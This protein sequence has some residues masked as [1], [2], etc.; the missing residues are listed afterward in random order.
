MCSGRAQ[1]REFK[2]E[3]QHWRI[4]ASVTGCVDSM[5]GCAKLRLASVLLPEQGRL[6]L[7]GLLQ[8][9]ERAP[10]QEQER[11][12]LQ[13]LVPAQVRGL[14]R[15]QE[16]RLLRYQGWLRLRVQMQHWEPALLRFDERVLARGPVMKPERGQ[17]RLLYPAPYRRLLR[18]SEQEPH[19][20]Q[21]L[22][23]WSGG[24]GKPGQC[25]SQ[26]ARLRNSAFW[27]LL[28]EFCSIRAILVT[29]RAGIRV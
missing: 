24:R 12:L 1:P 8:R 6:L 18:M 14:L 9:Q 27:Y 2:D 29:A 3:V 13:N 17:E 4:L 11:V 28:F 19:K 23:Q 21:A 20:G 15:Q 7:V 16:R 25:R 10:L 26:N 5:T 22:G